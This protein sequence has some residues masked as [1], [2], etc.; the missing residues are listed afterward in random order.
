MLSQNS[1]GSNNLQS[2]AAE[3]FY[4]FAFG[5]GSIGWNVRPQICGKW[6]NGSQRHLSVFYDIRHFPTQRPLGS[7]RTRKTFDRTHKGLSIDVHIDGKKMSHLFIWYEK[8]P[9]QSRK[10]IGSRDQNLIFQSVASC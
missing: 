2:I 6:L 4:N 10:G 7:G 9:G 3:P 1:R 8:P 5:S